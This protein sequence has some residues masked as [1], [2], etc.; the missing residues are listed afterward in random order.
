MQS[1]TLFIANIGIAWTLQCIRGK[2][3]ELKLRN[4]SLDRVPEM[5]LLPHLR[6]LDLRNNQIASLPLAGMDRMVSL[7]EL[8]LDHNRIRILPRALSN[9][10]KLRILSIR[11]NLLRDFPKCISV[12]SSLKEL[13]A[14]GNELFDLPVVIAA[15]PALVRVELEENPFVKRYPKF[16]T[17]SDH[18][19]PYL[20]EELKTRGLLKTPTMRVIVLGAEGVGKSSLIRGLQPTFGGDKKK[21]KTRNNTATSASFF[22]S[23][24][25]LVGGDPNSGGPP[26]GSP[27]VN[28]V[29]GSTTSLMNKSPVVGRTERSGTL[30]TTLP[31]EH[32]TSGNPAPHVGVIGG[33]VFTSNVSLLSGAMTSSS[34]D[35]SSGPAGPNILANN[36]HVWGAEGLG[37]LTTHSNRP[38]V[39]I[40]TLPAHGSGENLVMN[41]WEFSG[42]PAS[43]A[44]HSLF[45]SEIQTAY[46]IVFN[47]L[48]PNESQSYIEH[49]LHTVWRRAK[50]A[51]VILVG[52]HSDDKR[53][54]PDYIDNV[55]RSILFR[56]NAVD[57][58]PNLKQVYDVDTCNPAPALRRA[59]IELSNTE[60]LPPTP[61]STPKDKESSNADSDASRTYT[62]SVKPSESWLA[63]EERFNAVRQQA[64]QCQSKS[65]DFFDKTVRRAVGSK[66]PLSDV[67][68]GGTSLSGASTAVLQSLK[69]SI[70]MD[71]SEKEVPALLGYLSSSGAVTQF[72]SVQQVVLDPQWLVDATHAL[73]SYKT[74]SGHASFKLKAGFVSIADLPHHIWPAP[75]FPESDH[76]W[77]LQ[78]MEQT[79]SVVTVD[80][81]IFFAPYM[82]S[83]QPPAI[84]SG[85][86]DGDS[87]NITEQRRYYVFNYSPTYIFFKLMQ[88]LLMLDE[89]EHQVHWRYGIVM[90]DLRKTAQV[91]I[92]LD[93]ETKTVKLIVRGR[94]QVLKMVAIAEAIEQIMT[95]ASSNFK[96]QK[97]TAVVPCRHCIQEGREL[98]AA[99]F[100]LAS[101]E[102]AVNK[103]PTNALV[104]CFSGKKPRTV[105]VDW[106]APDVALSSFS[107]DRIEF[108]DIQLGDIIGEGGYA[109][110]YKGMWKGQIVAVKQVKLV[111]IVNNEAD[112][113]FAEFRREVQLMS[114]LQNENLVVLKAICMEPFC[115]VLDFMELG[116]LFEYTHSAAWA[117]VDWTTRISLALDIARGMRFL[118]GMMPPI[119]HRDLKSPNILLSMETPEESTSGER[120]LRAKVADFGLSRS[121]DFS[122]E[123]D[124]ASLE[125]NNPIWLAPEILLQQNYN[126]KV[127]IYSF[128][129]IL[130]EMISGQDFFGEI[131]F[132][133]DIEN[134]IVSGKRPNIN[135]VEDPFGVQ[136]EFVDLL[137]ICWDPSPSER[138][139]FDEIVP[140][141]V[142]LLQKTGVDV[143]DEKPAQHGSALA[144][145]VE[146]PVEPV[147]PSQ[148]ADVRNSMEG[149][150]DLL[151]AYRWSQSQQPEDGE[152]DD[153]NSAPSTPASH[154][155]STPPSSASPIA[156]PLAQET[157]SGAKRPKKEKTSR[158]KERSK[159]MRQHSTESSSTSA[160]A[161]SPPGS[162]KTHTSPSTHAGSGG[163]PSSRKDKEASKL[164]KQKR[165]KS[166]NFSGHGALSEDDDGASSSPTSSEVSGAS[167]LGQTA[168]RR[169]NSTR[170]RTTLL[171]ALGIADLAPAV[172]AQLSPRSSAAAA[173]T[174]SDSEADSVSG[175][176]SA[177]SNSSKVK[178]SK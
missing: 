132:M 66:P 168:G 7:E 173:I 175:S 70:S 38:S 30:T 147:I 28:S 43:L 158:D 155:G 11:K 172:R 25:D 48:Q 47:L 77:M 53:C 159:T 136:D 41:V 76:A 90:E 107:G 87:D 105:R 52:T 14:S 127:D 109:T 151:K 67:I 37:L 69:D 114:G 73:C 153:N 55:F 6:V 84:I 29:N 139:E 31:L 115:M 144:T 1:G 120:R 164:E 126:E 82:L 150:R 80:K 13:R 141:L 110:V 122:K 140:I 113:V 10:G 169:L 100:S 99:L 54:T 104:N 3:P 40:T 22:T 91:F 16:P 85:V 74:T 149:K 59:L 65:V 46:I 121:L 133:S 4:R 21:K 42:S 152:D 102:A 93:L 135:L 96:R 78:V 97:F 161:P 71:I 167:S 174:A 176:L 35:G 56:T 27:P 148:I 83:P 116:S 18:I 170:S 166:S 57:L 63:L 142:K 156:S 157:A 34:E 165:R 72:R 171:P 26:N 118:H 101:L 162:E 24:L 81:K 163:S 117:G 8:L 60:V 58:Y 106:L 75:K 137:K 124:G 123:L 160:V 130:F 143:A 15:M 86:W 33:S 154:H 111:N 108:K 131:A 9:L 112:N 95:E 134:L 2:G 51:P 79:E 5:I 61:L 49:W 94:Q 17:T 89:W 138:P 125:G 103:N 128:G 68:P 50:D 92:F 19:L 178:S 36:T 146:T 64:G 39:D 44:A 62:L 12:M 145:G 119:V 20:R 88:K 32:L 45:A 129:L 177:R 98:D 23:K